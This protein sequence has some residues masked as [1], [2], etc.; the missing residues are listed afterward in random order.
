MQQ[1]ADITKLFILSGNLNRAGKCLKQADQLLA[2]GNTLI[3]N[4]VATVYVHSLSR[5]LDSRTEQVLKV[6]AILPLSIRKE[7]D[8]QVSSLGV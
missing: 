3:K 1:F 6:M 8:L 4:A 7:Y 5:V 2:T